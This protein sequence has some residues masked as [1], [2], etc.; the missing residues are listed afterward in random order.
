MSEAVTIDANIEVSCVRCEQIHRY[1]DRP[2]KDCECFEISV[3]PYCGY[4]AYSWQLY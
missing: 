2:F 4:E 3:C 1:H